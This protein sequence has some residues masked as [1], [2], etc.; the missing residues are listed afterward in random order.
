MVAVLLVLYVVIF[1][2]FIGYSLMIT[3]FTPM[4]Y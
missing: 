3:V 2:G 4:V 1:T